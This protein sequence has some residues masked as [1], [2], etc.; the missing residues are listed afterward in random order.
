MIIRK[1]VLIG[2]LFISGCSTTYYN[3]NIT[4][5]VAL[6]R[7]K[8]IDEAHC[9]QVS[10]GSIPMPEVRHYQS[11]VQNY[12]INSTTRTY[13]TDGSSSTSYMSG[14]A[15]S[16]P[17]PGDAFSAGLANGASMGAALAAEKQRRQVMDGCMYT[18]GWTK[19]PVRVAKTVPVDYTKVSHK[20]TPPEE[21]QNQMKSFAETERR[22]LQEI[23]DVGEVLHAEVMK[24]IKDPEYDQ[25]SCTGVLYKALEKI[26]SSKSINKEDADYFE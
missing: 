13:N 2:F 22:S 5:P 20:N 24:V 1:T 23:E 26:K 11:G 14:Y 4:D 15:S 10:V 25:L 16:Y 6:E 8:T 18:L 12:Q 17:N 19:N 3:P 7:Q 9:T 21:C